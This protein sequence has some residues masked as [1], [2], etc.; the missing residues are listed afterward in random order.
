MEQLTVRGFDRELEQRL[1]TLAR[2]EGISL[3]QAAIR[4]MR[5]GAGLAPETGRSD[6][7]GHS[8]DRFF[9]VWTEDEERE[10]LESLEHCERIDEELW[11]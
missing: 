5:L 3:S 7:V 6:V 4:L 10:L 8:L 11:T 2:Q 1:R 9:G